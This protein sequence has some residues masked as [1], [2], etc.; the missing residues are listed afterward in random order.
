M[1]IVTY[2]KK[3]PLACAPTVARDDLS[4]AQYRVVKDRKTWLTL[5]SVNSPFGTWCRLIGWHCKRSSS[6][7]LPR[8]SNPWL[9]GNYCSHAISKTG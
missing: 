6:C 8:R 2:Q 5:A 1:A 3:Y 4:S 9:R 7:G